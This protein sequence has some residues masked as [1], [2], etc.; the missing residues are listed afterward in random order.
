MHGGL[1]PSIESI[2]HIRQLD[3]IMEVPNEGAVADLLWSDPSERSGW[4]VS[5]R[6]IGYVFGEDI[7]EQFNHCN[8]LK[9]VARAHQLMMDV[10]LLI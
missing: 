7:T 3:R 10:I 6:G 1:S 5:G 2:D 8:G 9:L 4:G